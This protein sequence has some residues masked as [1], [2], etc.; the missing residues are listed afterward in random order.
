VENRLKTQSK[1]RAPKPLSKSDLMRVAVD[2]AVRGRGSTHPNPAV[3]A[4]VAEGGRIVGRGFHRR[5]GLP[6]AEVEA[7]RDA[8]SRARGADLYVTLEPCCHQGQTPPCTR[9]IINAGIK[10]VFAAT[11]DPN[12]LMRGK[13]LKELR[14]AGIPVELGLEAEHSMKVNEAYLAFMNAGR[15]FVTLKAAQTLDGKI[16]TRTGDARWITSLSA[17]DRARAMRGEAQAIVV[18]VGTVAADDPLLLSSPPRKRDYLRCVLDANLSTPPTSRLARTAR[19]HPVVVYCARPGPEDS[20]RFARR[21]AMLEKKGVEVVT[22]RAT[23]VPG[24]GSGWAPA[25][26]RARVE[27]R[28]VLRDLAAR[29]V[30]HVWVEGGG[31]VFTSFLRAG[32]VDKMLAFVAPRIMGSGGSIDAFGDIGT[33][34]VRECFGLRV[35]SIE[36][37]GGDVLL[38]LYPEGPGLSIRR[39][40]RRDLEART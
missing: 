11:I 15:P 36:S 7:I 24:P 39:P 22:V 2:L 12:P 35:E 16:A 5:W 20:G 27:L 33:K 18:G 40:Q 32:L 8:G 4:V 34:S 30:M 13:G 6:H 1:K 3:G 29:R 14:R 26:F 31:A 17:R 23:R 9:A 21:K 38:T 28:E 10:R 19:A 37:I 25:A